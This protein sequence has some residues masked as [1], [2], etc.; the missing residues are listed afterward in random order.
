MLIDGD[1]HPRIPT[2]SWQNNAVLVATSSRLTGPASAG[3]A[4]SNFSHHDWDLWHVLVNELLHVR[5]LLSLAFCG[6]FCHQLLIV[7][8]LLELV[9][10]AVFVSFNCF[11]VQVK[12]IGADHI[13]ELA[14]VRD[15][16]QG[17][18]PA[19]TAKRWRVSEHD[20]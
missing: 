8:Y 18:A 15:H 19:P 13:Q 20:A 12:R 10:V 17:V 6:T 5:D 9:V 3:V 4:Y 16:D 14:C 7:A 2:Q 11:V 1:R